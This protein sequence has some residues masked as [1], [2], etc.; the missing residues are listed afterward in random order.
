MPPVNG[1]ST[2]KETL[3][4]LHNTLEAS[5][6]KQK[7]TVK[8]RGKALFECQGNVVSYNPEHGLREVSFSVIWLIQEKNS[9]TFDDNDAV[10][11]S[12]DQISLV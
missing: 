9:V 7:Q 6:V 8:G 3:K 11:Y 5:K 12:L 10:L 1:E 2:S 4:A